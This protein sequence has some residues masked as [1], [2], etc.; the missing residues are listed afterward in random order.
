MERGGTGLIEG[1]AMPNGG[2]PIGFRQHRETMEYQ[3][4][5]STHS[6][7]SVGYKTLTRGFGTGA[8]TFPRSILNLTTWAAGM[9]KPNYGGR[10]VD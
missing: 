7:M 1:S 9:D 4:N 5:Q 6:N 10:D 2:V 3:T 8:A